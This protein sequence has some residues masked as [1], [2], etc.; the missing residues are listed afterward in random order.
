[1][2][3]I[4][5]IPGAPLETNCYLVADTQ[6]GEALLVDAPWQIASTISGLLEELCVTVRLIVCTHGH[7]DHCMGLPELIAATGA[8]VACHP[9]DAHLLEHPSFAPFSFPFTLTPVVP[10]RLLVE[11]DAVTVGG[12][13]FKVLHTPGHTPGCICLYAA[14]DQL[15]F[16]GDTLFAGTCGRMDL[17]GGDPEAMVRS[18]QRLRA[19]PPAVT[20][21][22]GHGAS[23]TLA[24]EHHWLAQAEDVG[25]W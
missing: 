8:P 17:P 24:R 22:P 2:L 3:T 12:S 19:L 11:G 9:N 20:V 4:H 10:D 18:L 16:S 7:W 6:A 14:E 21:Y 5:T 23:T 15:L 1:M 13:T 25:E